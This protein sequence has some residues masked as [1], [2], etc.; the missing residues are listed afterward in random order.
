MVQMCI[1]YY[2]VNLMHG[3]NKDTIPKNLFFGHFSCICY[4]YL[5]GG[6]MTRCEVN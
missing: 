4:K 1:M 2:Y 5:G 3:G 6:V